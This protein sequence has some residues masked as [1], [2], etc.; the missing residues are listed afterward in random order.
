M[1]FELILHQSLGYPMLPL[2]KLRYSM[3]SVLCVT[4]LYALQSRVHSQ[5]QRWWIFLMR[6]L[7]DSNQQLHRMLFPYNLHQLWPILRPHITFLLSEM[8]HLV[9]CSSLFDLWRHF[10]VFWMF[11]SHSPGR[12]KMSFLQ[13]NLH[14]RDLLCKCPRRTWM[15]KLSRRL[16]SDNRHFD[17]KTCVQTLHESG[18]LL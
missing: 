1:C 12:R 15:L 5:T 13:L 10:W 14:V 16:L 18:K 8:R 17:W 9:D 7:F 2:S 3:P 4:T 11:Q 6:T